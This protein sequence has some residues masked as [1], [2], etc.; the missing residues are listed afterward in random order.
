M[1]QIADP[2]NDPVNAG[3]IVDPPVAGSAPV[4]GASG[5]PSS[6]VKIPS[7]SSGVT[8]SS[9]TWTICPGTYVG[10]VQINGTASVTMVSGVYYM[11]GGGFSVTG[12]ASLNGAA[13]VMIYNSSGSISGV[14]TTPATVDTVP[15][16]VNGKKD[17]KLANGL[18]SDNNPSDLG[19]TVNYTMT[20]DRAGGGSPSPA[21]TVS[22]YDGA[23]ANGTPAPIA[24]CQNLPLVSAGGTKAKATCANQVYNNFGTRAIL[25]IYWGNAVYNARGDTLTQTINSSGNIAPVTLATSGN[26]QIKGPS[27]GK[28]AGLVIFQDRTSNLT[29]TLQPGSGLAACAGNWLTQD[30]PD[31]AGTEPPAACGP[32]GGIQGTIYAPA[33]TALVFVTASGVANL[34][35][36][37][38][39][40]Q[41]DS[42][43][44]A[45]FAYTPQFFANGAIRLIE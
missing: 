36:I 10:G 19:E 37:A 15:A 22:F 3:N 4:A 17:P 14:S 1:P 11:A 7:G 27:S 45:R 20:L 26:I 12:S 6:G 38:G 39:K 23:L 43:A 9:G 33:Q 29:V 31:A 18:T 5:C 21:G 28:Y 32:L 35:V 41:V 16:K 13:G 24:A 2:L 30:V 8:I 42:N 25:A 44:D 34:Q 40:I